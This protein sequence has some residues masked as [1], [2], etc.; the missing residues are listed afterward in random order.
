VP[1]PELSQTE[2]RIVLLVAQGRSRREIAVVVGLDTRTVDWHLA[3]AN[4]K[5][6]KASALLDQV[7][8]REQ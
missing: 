3:Q 6:E 1:V 7:R 8:G 2:E 4:L 5:L